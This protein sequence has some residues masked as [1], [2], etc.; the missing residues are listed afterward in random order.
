MSKRLENAVKME[1][2]TTWIIRAV[3]FVALVLLIKGAFVAAGIAALFAYLTDKVRIS[4]ENKIYHYLA[5]GEGRPIVI[6]PR[7][8]MPNEIT[9]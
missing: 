1:T 5:M 8:I 9:K 6:N 3:L 4:Y 7:A 2:I